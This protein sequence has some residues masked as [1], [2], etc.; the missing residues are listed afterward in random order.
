MENY[1]YGGKVSSNEV[2][3]S[4]EFVLLSSLQ[5][6]QLSETRYEK[7]WPSRRF[8]GLAFISS[9]AKSTF[10]SHRELK[11]AFHFSLANKDG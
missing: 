3:V 5:Q 11:N 2:K 4:L 6:P 1:I 9:Q 10:S 8:G 7:R